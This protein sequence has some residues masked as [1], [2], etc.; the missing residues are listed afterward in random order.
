MHRSIKPL[1][2]FCE[3]RKLDP[4]QNNLGNPTPSQAPRPHNIPPPRYDLTMTR[5][6]R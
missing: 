5:P 3:R 6:R 4:Q 1:G 2:S